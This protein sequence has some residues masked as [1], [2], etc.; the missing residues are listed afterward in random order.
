ML[1]L[2]AYFTCSM[3]MVPYRGCDVIGLVPGDVS[4]KHQTSE[5]KKKIYSGQPFDF[6]GMLVAQATDSSLAVQDSS[7]TDQEASSFRL[8]DGV[9]GNPGSVSLRLES[10]KGCFVYSDETLKGNETEA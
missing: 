9:D 1:F 5:F 7:S 8:V 10:K 4:G 3:A 6:P 2:I